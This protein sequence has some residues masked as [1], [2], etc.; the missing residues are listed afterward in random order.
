MKLYNV[1]TWESLQSFNYPLCYQTTIRVFL[2]RDGTKF[3]APDEEGL[4]EWSFAEK[5]LTKVIP[6]FKDFNILM[7]L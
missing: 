6:L 3:W 7:E 4:K 2:S 1:D 5:K